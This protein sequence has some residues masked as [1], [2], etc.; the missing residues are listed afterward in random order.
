MQQRKEE[1]ARWELLL[2]ELQNYSF[3]YE[4]NKYLMAVPRG[5]ITEG[6]AHV[7]KPENQ[8]MRLWLCIT[9]NQYPNSLRGIGQV[10]RYYHGEAQ[11]PITA[12][13]KYGFEEAFGFTGYSA[14]TSA[15]A[16]VYS[17]PSYIERP[18]PK[19]KGSSR[20]LF[21]RDL[22]CKV[23]PTIEDATVIK[24]IEKVSGS[25]LL[26][27]VKSPQVSVMEWLDIYTNGCFLVLL[28]L[29]REGVASPVT[30]VKTKATTIIQYCYP[31]E[32][33]AASVV[34]SLFNSLT[35]P[36]LALF[37]R[38]PEE[39]DLHWPSLFSGI[40]PSVLR[41]ILVKY[42]KKEIEVNGWD[43]GKLVDT[44]KTFSPTQGHKTD[45]KIEILKLFRENGTAQDTFPWFSTEELTKWLNPVDAFGEG[46]EEEEVICFA[47]KTPKPKLSKLGQLLEANE[48]TNPGTT[49]FVQAYEEAGYE[50]EDLETMLTELNNP[51]TTGLL[52]RLTDPQRMKLLRV[53][54][55]AN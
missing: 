27:A 24:E 28:A 7:I 35:L 51:N 49:A 17:M 50:Y 44:V 41:K 54:R 6:I 21:F 14:P 5:I 37:L 36:R 22:H 46:I 3:M 55:A 19:A 30:A 13:E 53:W 32:T 10:L 34:D 38:N 39:D 47:P 15:P 26:R 16:P 29:I 9:R 8:T 43:A 18:A 48:M 52:K 33:I 12:I 1:N 31:E 11:M 45:Y 4:F 25:L 20:V 40:K 2:D 42:G 23:D